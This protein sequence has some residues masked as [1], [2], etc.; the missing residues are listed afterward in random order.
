MTDRRFS[1]F[2]TGSVINA[3]VVLMSALCVLTYPKE[4]IVQSSNTVTV[5]ITVCVSMISANLAIMASKIATLN[6]SNQDYQIPQQMNAV[7]VYSVGKLSQLLKDVLGN[8]D[9][10]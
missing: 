4:N 10:K 5:M 8:S 2:S 9:T 7:S 3:V 6:T 1:F